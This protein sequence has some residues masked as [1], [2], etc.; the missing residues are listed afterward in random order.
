MKIS[1]VVIHNFRSILDSEFDLADYSLLVGE[2]NAGK[3]T[4]IS[5]LRAFYEDAV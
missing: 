5:A 2:N 3:T 4:V 1:K